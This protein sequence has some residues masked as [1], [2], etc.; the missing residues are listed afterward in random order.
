M[1][2]P[3]ADPT[4][5]VLYNR[6]GL[7]TAEA[8]DQ[9]ERLFVASRARDF[10]PKGEFD[11]DHLRSIH[12]HLFQ[13]VYDWAGELRTVEIEKGDSVFMPASLIRRGMDDI[14]WRLVDADH[15]RGLQPDAFAAAA[16]D[17]LADIN[18]LH[19]FREGNGRVQLQFFGQLAEGAG[20]AV[21]LTR[22]DRATWL[23]ASIASH[24]RDLTPMTE[25][26]RDTVIGPAPERELGR[27]RGIDL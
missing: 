11:L 25:A 20:H 23:D 7:T 21:D 13:D 2:D 10:V 4:T 1:S 8:L 6:L 19:P 3:Y 9:A 26:L 24:T 27:D 15:L 14:H 12:R 16:A 17:L 5:G 18:H 22:L